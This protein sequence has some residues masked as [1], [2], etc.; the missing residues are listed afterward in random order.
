MND[1]FARARSLFIYRA[2]TLYI[3]LV[4]AL[5]LASCRTHKDVGVQPV[6]PGG[7]QAPVERGGTEERRV[8]IDLSTARTFM[9]NNTFVSSRYHFADLNGEQ[10]AAAQKYG[11]EPVQGRKEAERLVRRLE[12]VES[13]ELYMVDELTHSVPYLTKSAKRLLDDMGRIYQKSL[14]A[15]GYRPHRFI[16]TSLLRTR[17][18]VDRLRRVN[19]NASRNSSHMYGTTFDISWSRYNRVSVDGNTASNNTLAAYLGECIYYLRDHGRCV[20]IY[21][22]NQHCFHITVVE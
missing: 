15:G 22:Q 21:E 20:V 18:D 6:L 4:A 9:D 13:C 14:I 10:L 17:E 2:R 7:G 19:A 11:V 8:R 16:V 12:K 5:V 1:W 3:C